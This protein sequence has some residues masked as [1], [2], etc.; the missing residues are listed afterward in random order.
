MADRIINKNDQQLLQA[1]A[2]ETMACASLQTLQQAIAMVQ[3]AASQELS[4]GEQDTH[5]TLLTIK[6]IAR[7]MATMPGQRQII[8]VSPGFVTPSVEALEETTDILDRATRGNV[9]ISSVDA[10]GLFTG[11]P[12]ISQQSYDG[13]ATMVKAQYDREAALA[14]EDVLA[15]LA[16]GTGGTFFHD[17][18]DLNEGFRRVATA[19]E[20]MYLLGFSPDRLKND[21]TF[22]KLKI[23]LVERKGLNVQARLGYYAPKRATS[24]EETSKAEIADAVFS[25]EEIHD[26]PMDLHTQFFKPDP[27]EAKLTVLARIDV[28]QLRFKKA[29]NRNNDNL[30]IVAV[31]FDTNGN[32]I[33]GVQK[34]LEM[35]LLDATLQKLSGPVTLKSDFNVKPGTYVVRLVVR[36]AQGQMMAAQNGVVDIP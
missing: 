4:L 30:T 6:D 9:M 7:R 1:V 22:H 19:P 10:R 35:R 32:Y 5:V 11:T 14:Q 27:T 13:H 28:R 34:T 21:G 36:D 8:L 2:A 17:N 29:N 25:R 15:E 33:T 3:A 18:N 12:D 23:V 24:Q 31:L 26:L 16:S 20:Y